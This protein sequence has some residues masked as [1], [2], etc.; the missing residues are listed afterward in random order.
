[1]DTDSTT[2]TVGSAAFGHK[3][4][5][6]KKRDTV[7]PL[8][9]NANAR[10]KD[11]PTDATAM[12]D[13]ETG[14]EPATYG[15]QLAS[16][17]VQEGNEV[18]HLRAEDS[19]N[20]SVRGALEIQ[21]RLLRLKSLHDAV[22]ALHMVGIANCPE[23]WR[24]LEH[25]SSELSQ[26]FADI[27]STFRKAQEAIISGETNTLKVHIKEFI[28]RNRQLGLSPTTPPSELEKF[29]GQMPVGSA[30]LSRLKTLQSIAT[31]N[32]EE[33]RFLLEDTMYSLWWVLEKKIRDFARK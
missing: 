28:Q 23:V 6:D 2:I 18:R 26:P 8:S 27:M 15:A 21:R 5:T 22:W 25:H 3:T 30:V 17:I 32:T 14:T 13:Y 11:N 9:L 16:L 29:M 31:R 12:I 7:V 33:S 1:M 19:E 10:H 4:L 24:L 20:P